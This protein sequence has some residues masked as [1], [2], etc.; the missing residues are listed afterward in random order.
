MKNKKQAYEW[1]LTMSKGDDHVLT[2]AQYEHYKS[3]YKEGKIFFDTFE[4]NPSFVM[5]AFMQP[6]DITKRKYPCRD[7]NTNGVAYENEQLIVCKA[8]GGT[9]LDL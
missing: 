6:A 5:S 3:S 1:V 9:G 2:E 8:C 4:V 7:C